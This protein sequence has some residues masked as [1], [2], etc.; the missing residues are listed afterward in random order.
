MIENFNTDKWFN[1]VHGHNYFPFYNLIL[2]D[3]ISKNINMLEI[4]IAQG[5]SLKMWDLYFENAKIYGWDI[6]N[7]SNIDTENIKT[8]IVD[9]GNEIEINN[10]FKINDIYFDFIIDDGSH[11]FK[12]Q[13]ISLFNL[14]D[15]LKHNG[16]YIIEDLWH[17]TFDCFLKIGYKKNYIDNIDND[18]KK[19]INNDKINYLLCCQKNNVIFSSGEDKSDHCFYVFYKK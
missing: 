8:F 13:C 16:I 1:G 5:A 12:D 2:K 4:G 15:R 19:I 18:I 3:L 11:L 7:C 17:S 10:F 6:N 14:F 9:Q